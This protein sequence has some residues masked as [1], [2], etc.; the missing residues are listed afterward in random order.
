[1]SL[2]SFLDGFNPRLASLMAIAFILGMSIVGT[3]LAFLYRVT[4]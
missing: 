2:R 4:H 1:M 3:S